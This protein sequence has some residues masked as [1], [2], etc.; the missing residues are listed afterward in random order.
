MKRLI[1]YILPVVVVLISC[2]Q[3]AEGCTDIA[4]CNYDPDANINN[5]SCWY[6][7]GGCTCDDGADAED[8]DDDG[9]CD[10]EDTF[11]NYSIYTLSSM[12]AYTD[13][14]CSGSATAGYCTSTDTLNVSDLDCML[15]SYD[16]SYIAIDNCP[17]SDECNPN[18]G[19]FDGCCSWTPLLEYLLDGESS[20]TILLNSDGSGT[21][22]DSSGALNGTWTEEE[23]VVT[24]NSSTDSDGDDYCPAGTVE[25]CSGDCDCCPESWIGDGYGDC[26]DQYWECDLSCY[27]LDGGDCGSDESGGDYTGS[28]DEYSDDSNLILVVSGNT[29]LAQV[30]ENNGCIEY[31]FTAN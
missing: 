4:A 6:A 13:S 16:L 11:I 22:N 17:G 9:I 5:S 27:D 25:D 10:N 28:C 12:V 15:D 26:S 21:L 1:I 8:Y 14:S 31:L 24:F 30:T 23:G 18:A 2:E 29:L 19:N 3:E 7:D 20:P